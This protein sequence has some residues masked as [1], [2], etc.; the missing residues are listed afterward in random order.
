MSVIEMNMDGLVGP[1][2]HYAG[3]SHGNIASAKN[4]RQVAN[5]RAAA[6]QG[7]HKM[8]VMHDLGL[9]Q[10]VLPPPAA[11]RLHVLRDLGFSGSPSKI[12]SECAKQAP[13][14]LSAISSAAAMWAANAA[15]V[16]ASADTSDGRVHFTPANLQ[17]TFHRSLETQATA[18][19][20]KLIFKDEKRFVH[21]SALP[22]HPQFA[23]EGAANHCRLWHPPEKNG[24]SVF[25]YG[26]SA[27][28]TGHPKTLRFPARQALEASEAVAR[29]HGLEPE[30][31]F[32]VQQ[33]PE[34]IDAG[35]FHNDVVAVANKNLFFCH[36][37]AFVNQKWIEKK[38][39]NTFNTAEHHLQ[40]FEVSS[41]RLSLHEAV[42]SYLFN[43][44]IVSLPDGSTVILVPEECQENPHV[45]NL[46]AELT[47]TGAP[48]TRVITT[49]L[50]QSMRNGGG[51]AC[52]RLRIP[53]NEE[54]FKAVHYGV[55]F[56]EELY[57]TLQD[58]INIHYRDKI[59]FDDLKDPLF[60]RE[61]EEALDAL[62]TIL[63]LGSF[64][65][66]QQ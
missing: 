60:Y 39:K 29:S 24:I 6:L 36:E 54:E 9:A 20:L 16:S 1:S 30:H 35:A 38:L 64:Y 61:A 22:T 17:S 45:R 37:Q 2:H 33:N 41:A 46:L 53:L 12:L 25:V 14:L 32:F 48:F 28:Q 52:L 13:E 43:S 34:A 56:S 19:I 66:F 26:R 47:G 7:L 23:D 3:L 21:H 31:C 10:G 11:P 49:D 55:L 5:P 50:Q 15:T 57:A 18:R 27:Y 58:W 62:S 51:P 59:C 63:K 42:H 44:Q 8:K 65:A 4:A 40:W